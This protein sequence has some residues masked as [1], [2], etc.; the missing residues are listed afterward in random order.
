MADNNTDDGEEA[1][2][3]YDAAERKGFVVDNHQQK[4]Q[5]E[6]C[7]EGAAKVAEG[8]ERDFH[9]TV[10]ADEH[11]F[12]RLFVDSIEVEHKGGDAGCFCNVVLVSHHFQYLLTC[13]E[14]RI[15]L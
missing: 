14:Q 8:I 6:C 13:I 2:R 5:N 3:Q 11:F 4:H 15:D 7:N 12:A 9:L 10:P 1:S